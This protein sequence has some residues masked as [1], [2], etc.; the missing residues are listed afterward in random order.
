M[1]INGN[2]IKELL[3]IEDGKQLGDIIKDLKNKL[4]S[5]EVEE[6]FDDCK[7]YILNKYKHG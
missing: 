5:N 2:D 7:Q 4:L 1:P 6:T 3:N